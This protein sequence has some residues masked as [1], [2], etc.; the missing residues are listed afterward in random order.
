LSHFCA[1]IPPSETNGK[2]KAVRQT[3]PLFPLR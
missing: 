1:P 2:K 3:Q